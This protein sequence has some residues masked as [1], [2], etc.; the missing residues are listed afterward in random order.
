MLGIVIDCV[1]RDRRASIVVQ[2]FAGIGVHVEARELAAGDVNPDAV[3][4]LFRSSRGPSTAHF[5]MRLHRRVSAVS[6]LDARQI[7]MRPE[8][9]A[10]IRSSTAGAALRTNQVMGAANDDEIAGLGDRGFLDATVD[11][12]KV[13]PLLLPPHPS[14]P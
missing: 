6:T 12:G 14:P 1:H 10:R 13:Q 4:F 2:R 9:G 3:A 5:P 7:R 11:Q 8:P